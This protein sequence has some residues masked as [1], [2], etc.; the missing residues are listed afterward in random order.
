M[1]ESCISHNQYLNEVKCTGLTTHLSPNISFIFGVFTQ[2]Y[3]L[4]ILLFLS[5]SLV[6][7]AITSCEVVS[8]NAKKVIFNIQINLSFYLWICTWSF[9]FISILC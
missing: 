3:R 4:V 2:I 5:S 1:K 9:Y 6:V 8:S 7:A